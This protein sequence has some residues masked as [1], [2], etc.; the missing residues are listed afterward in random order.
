M[1]PTVAVCCVYVFIKVE[2]ATNRAE[3]HYM[4]Q[5]LKIADKANIQAD[6]NRCRR[7]EGIIVEY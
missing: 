7:D 5:S 4:T 3:K 1:S 2:M 6:R